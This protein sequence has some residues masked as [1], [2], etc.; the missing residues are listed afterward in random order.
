MLSEDANEKSINL[1]VKVSKV[2]GKEL[3]KAIEKALVYLKNKNKPGKE[4]DKTE[5]KV[6]AGRTTMKQLNERSNG[7]SSI[8]LKSP[9]LKM[10]N[11]FMKKHGVQFAVAKDG[12]NTYT[13]FFKAKDVDSVNHAFGQYA[14]KFLKLNRASPSIRQN[15]SK[16]RVQAQTHNNNRSAEKNRNRG[17]L[18]R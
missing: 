18:E 6:K 2:S 14:R 11:G 17:G 13:L 7:L 3:L 10:L 5:E 12:K 9:D 16:A 8:E 15:L 1:A 4:K